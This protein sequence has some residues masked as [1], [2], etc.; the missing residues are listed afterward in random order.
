MTFMETNRLRLRNINIKDADEMFDY[1]NNEICSKYQKG[2]TKDYD[3]IVALAERRKD[4]T[5][6][7]ESPSFISV[8]LKE[9][10]VIIGEIVVMPNEGT[11]SLG[12]TFSYKV[13]RKGYAYEA[14]SALIEYLHE[15]YPEWDYV[16]F[17]ETEN[18]PSMELLKKLGFTDL[19]YLP[20]KDS[21]VLGK[22]LRQ[23]TAEE[24]A[25]TVQ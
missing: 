23:D 11:I 13:H 8:A 20:S 21:Q 12:Y 15:H 10:N 25:Q 4:D 2:Q 18:V 19:G 3:G 6:T 16:C 14:L 5:L 17:T 7:M 24:I 22:W 1:R 9:T